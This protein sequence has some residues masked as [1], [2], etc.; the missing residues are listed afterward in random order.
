MDYKPLIHITKQTAL[1]KYLVHWLEEL[2]T[3]SMHTVYHPVTLDWVAK[4]LSYNGV[5]SD[6]SKM[7][8]PT[9]NGQ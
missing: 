6:S 5:E 1:N 4:A 2:A 7:V 3:K 9:D 8:S